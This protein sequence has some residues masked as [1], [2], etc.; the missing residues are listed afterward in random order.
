[1]QKFV[2]L[3]LRI[4]LR[5]QSIT[6]AHT[7]QILININFRSTEV[8]K[9]W[10]WIDTFIN[11]PN[12]RK[13]LTIK[14]RLS[15]KTPPCSIINMIQVM[16]LRFHSKQQHFPQSTKS[17]WQMHTHMNGINCN[18]YLMLINVSLKYC[19]TT[20]WYISFVT[21]CFYM[22]KK[23]FSN[24]RP[25]QCCECC[26]AFIFAACIWNSSLFCYSYWSHVSYLEFVNNCLD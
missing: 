15:Y 26:S 14:Y 21:C 2:P 13:L 22:K 10:N 3:W 6:S 24:R 17:V 16:Y 11:S 20:K 23:H 5:N 7:Q 19:L 1:M 18:F 4:C 25:S 8:C 12:D 9:K